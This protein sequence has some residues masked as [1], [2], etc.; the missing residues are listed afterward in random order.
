M[1]AAPPVGAD[2][3]QIRRPV[4][5]FFHDQVGNPVAEGLYLQQFSLRRHAGLARKV[6]RFLQNPP[7][8]LPEAFQDRGHVRIFPLPVQRHLVHHVDDAQG[9]TQAL[10]KGNGLAQ[11]MIGQVAAIDGNQNMLVHGL[12]LGAPLLG[13]C[14]TNS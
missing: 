2:H 11:G 7:A 1:Q 6:L 13:E 10:R 8:R 14:P 4:L 5:G 3:D 9:G 12:L